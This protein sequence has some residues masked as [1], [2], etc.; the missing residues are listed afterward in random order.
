MGEERICGQARNICLL[1]IFPPS[2]ETAP[3]PHKNS[4]RQGG[5]LPQFENPTLDSSRSKSRYLLSMA[6]VRLSSCVETVSNSSSTGGRK[7]TWG[8]GRGQ[9]EVEDE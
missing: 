3:T 5:D 2:E 6:W 9:D 1:S 8:R 7:A 4:S